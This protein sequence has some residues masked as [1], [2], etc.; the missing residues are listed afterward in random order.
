MCIDALNREESC[1]SHSRTEHIN[2]NGEAQRHDDDYAFISAWQYS[3]NTSQPILNKE[4]L[5]FEFIKPN[6]RNY[7]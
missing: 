7:R 6:T 3:G 4:T 1:G 5:D 2:A